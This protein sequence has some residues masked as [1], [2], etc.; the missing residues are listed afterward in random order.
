MKRYIFFLALFFSSLQFLYAQNPDPHYVKDC[1]RK[2][3]VIHSKDSIYYQRLFFKAFPSN[4]KTFARYYGRDEKTH[5]GQPLASVPSYYFKR[6]FN[7]KAYSRKA[8]L[9][10]IIGVSVNGKMI[11]GAVAGFEEDC[12]NFALDHNIEFIDVLQSFSNADIVSVWAFYFDYPNS[13]YRRVDYQK[14]RD[15]TA[16]HNKPMAAL[17][18]RGYEKAVAKWATHH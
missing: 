10:K 8:L 11:H 2:G 13:R 6:F 18:T 7:S 4:F 15:L 5:I 14:I 12:F 17:I 16:R 3:F 1:F 9:K